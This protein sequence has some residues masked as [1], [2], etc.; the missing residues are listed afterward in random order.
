MRKPY[1]YQCI[2][3]TEDIDIKFYGISE[4]KEHT[5]DI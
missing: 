1:T 3:A 5:H 2:D 4:G